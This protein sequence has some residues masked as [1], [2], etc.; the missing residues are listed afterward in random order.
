VETRSGLAVGERDEMRLRVN[1]GGGRI[2][3]FKGRDLTNTE[4]G[5]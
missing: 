4:K 1:V 2:K 3:E 5:G